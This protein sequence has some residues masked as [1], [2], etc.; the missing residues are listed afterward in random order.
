MFSFG[1]TMLILAVICLIAGF[2][3]RAFF[4]VAIIAFVIA[5]FMGVFGG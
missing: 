5:W 2:F 1:I 3:A 4:A